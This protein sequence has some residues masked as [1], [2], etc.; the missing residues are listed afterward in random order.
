MITFTEF[1]KHEMYQSFPEFYDEA[2][3]FFEI[4]KGETSIGFIGVRPLTR[5]GGELE[6]YI[7]PDY[8]R[9]LT[10]DFVFH[11]M[12]FPK[13]LGYQKTYMFPEHPS[14]R[15]FFEFLGKRCKL[16]TEMLNKTLYFVRDH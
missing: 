14:V 13:T 9:S 1:D 6:L 7:S 11:L 8:R 3:R 4:M 15:H 5:E 2:G 10:R 16:Y 12:D